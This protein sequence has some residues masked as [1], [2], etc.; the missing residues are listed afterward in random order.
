MFDP[1]NETFNLKEK[2]VHVW[3]TF[4]EEI[5]SPCLLNYYWD[6]LSGEEQARCERF[7]FQTHKEEY[8]ISHAM[9]RTVLAAYT[10]ILP[11]RLE[12]YR[13]AYGR[14]ELISDSSWMR[15]IRFNLS[16]TNGVVLFALA[17]D[18]EIGVDVEQNTRNLKLLEITNRF[19]TRREIEVLQ[20]LP[21]D[22]RKNR[23]F[24]FWTLKESYFK[25]LGKGLHIPLDEVGFYISE[26]EPKEIFFNTSIAEDTKNRQ[27]WLFNP[28]ENFTAA[29]SVSRKKNENLEI[30][31]WNT[32]PLQSVRSHDCTLITSGNLS[33]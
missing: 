32:I 21:D 20:H 31:I 3:L 7:S 4:L 19:F 28:A 8:L 1:N 16:H 24:E 25:A 12:F 23:F 18:R 15:K 10:N 2:Q 13:Q 11:Q 22:S 9:L 30:N 6:L 26:K 14:P 17:W 33:E 29:I 27:F 5:K